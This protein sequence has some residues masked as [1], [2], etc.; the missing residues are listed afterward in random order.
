MDDKKILCK[1]K[2][3]FVEN[4]YVVREKIIYGPIPLI[5]II[6][7]SSLVK[8]KQKVAITSKNIMPNG[9]PEFNKS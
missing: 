6:Q 5:T 1:F 8:S 2:T 4:R 3:K 7:V 9:K